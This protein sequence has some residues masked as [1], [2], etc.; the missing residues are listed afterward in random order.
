VYQDSAGVKNFYYIH[1]DHLGSWLKITDQSGNVKNRYSYDAW[2]RPR[3]PST[4]ALMPIGITDALI[5]N[6]NA[7]QPR[8][9]RGYTG[10]E[11]MCGFG[12][13]NMNGRL[14]DPYLQRFLSPDNYVQS[15]ENAQSYNRYSYCLN[16]PLM[17]TDPS[18]W[19]EMKTWEDFWSVVSDLWNSP[20][21]GSWSSTTGV[22]YYASK[23]D[24]L[25]GG[26]DYNNATGG[27]AATLYS[28]GA[29]VVE[30]NPV[31]KNIGKGY[32]SN[33]SGY[34]YKNR[35]DAIKYDLVANPS[36]WMNPSSEGGNIIDALISLY[37][38]DSQVKGLYT[39]YYKE[40][41]EIFMATHG[42]IRRNAVQSIEIPKGVLRL[43]PSTISG[44]L[45]HEF[46]HV[47]QRSVLLMMDKNEREFDAFHSQFFDRPDVPRNINSLY[48]YYDDAINRYGGMYPSLQLKHQRDLV[49][50]TQWLDNYYG[51]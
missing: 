31:R 47:Y 1:T 45:I 16:N 43:S 20:N 9:D 12:L 24:A 21:G 10:H 18:G 15:P 39:I 11:H 41:N 4:W 44:M 33:G 40:S 49:D 3:S 42:T 34:L 48:D 6:L 25:R 27:W 36:L 46:R 28:N 13:I 22:S 23:G 32:W 50:F 19:N 29:H 30:I 51:F 26:V 35:A 14:Y 7:M 37:N 38:L 5:N 8:F 2:G 17:Y